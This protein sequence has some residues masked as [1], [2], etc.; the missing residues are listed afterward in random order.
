VRFES[1]TLRELKALSERWD[2]LPADIIRFAVKSLLREAKSNSGEIKLPF[3]HNL[4]D[5]TP[6]DV[7]KD[8]FGATPHASLSFN[9]SFENSQSREL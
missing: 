8:A 9:A 4:K 3:R 7:P 6:K 5:D 1:E 2:L